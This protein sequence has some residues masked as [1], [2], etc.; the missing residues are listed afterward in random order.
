VVRL[1]QQRRWRCLYR[2]PGDAAG[3]TNTYTDG[4]TDTYTDG[5]RN[6]YCYSYSNGQT[7]SYA[8]NCANTEASSYTSAKAVVVFAKVKHYCDRR[9][10]MGDRSRRA[11]RFLLTTL[12]CASSRRNESK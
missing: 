2:S 5:Y 11:Y 10:A 8:E 1:A 3:D 9:Q 7:Y 6:T 12:R 4:N